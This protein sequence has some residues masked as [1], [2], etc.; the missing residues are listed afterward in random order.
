MGRLNHVKWFGSDHALFW[1]LLDR[2]QRSHFVALFPLQY[3]DSAYG[4]LHNVHKD[5]PQKYHIV[6]NLGQTICVVTRAF[7]RELGY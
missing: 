4:F 5:N 1:S 2:L 6:P 7:D 3:H